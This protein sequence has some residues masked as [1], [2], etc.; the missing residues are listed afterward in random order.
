MYSGV[1]AGSSM[2]RAT[3]MLK[4][5]VVGEK[6]QATHIK[7]SK[8]TQQTNT[9]NI[10]HDWRISMS[11]EIQ[12]L[13]Y[14]VLRARAVSGVFDV[15]LDVMRHEYLTL[16]HRVRIAQPPPSCEPSPAASACRS[17]NMRAR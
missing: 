6:E 4:L 2:G 12:L 13:L 17:A 5:I 10:L 14:T 16:R 15:L 1:R 9:A 7:H 11:P 8:Q 3:R